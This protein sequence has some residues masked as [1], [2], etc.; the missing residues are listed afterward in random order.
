MQSQVLS[1]AS[2]IMQLGLPGALDD[3][4]LWRVLCN[5]PREVPVAPTPAASLD[6]P[7]VD[8][9]TRGLPFLVR[10]LSRQVY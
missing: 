3:A 2:N 5:V 7:S 4:M 9:T 1:H 10:A 6:Q 8:G